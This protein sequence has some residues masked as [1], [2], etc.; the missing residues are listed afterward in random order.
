MRQRPAVKLQI[1]LST[2]SGN[3]EKQE[4]VGNYRYISYN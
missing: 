1:K 3:L 4:L 2:N